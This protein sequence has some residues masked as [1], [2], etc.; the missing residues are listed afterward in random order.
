[1]LARLIGREALSHQVQVVKD[2]EP[3]HKCANNAKQ[4][5]HNQIVVLLLQIVEHNPAVSLKLLPRHRL[6]LCLEESFVFDEAHKDLVA[7][8][9]SVHTDDSVRKDKAEEEP[10]VVQAHALIDPDAV[11]VKLLDTDV[12]SGAVLGTRWF[13]KLARSASHLLFKEQAIELKPLDCRYVVSALCILVKRA[14]VDPAGCEVACIA[15]YH[16]ESAGVDMGVRGSLIGQHGEA[17][18]GED[19]E[20][21]KGAYTVDDLHQGVRLVHNVPDDA[22]YKPDKALSTDASCSFLQ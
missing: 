16:E 12:A 1:M 20:P 3:K 5:D 17:L 19:V 22:L 8:P 15:N 21:S 18:C 6:E 7:E 10:V 13:V 14:W 9:G 4:D 11:V 2:E